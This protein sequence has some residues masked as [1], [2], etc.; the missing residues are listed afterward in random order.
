MQDYFNKFR[1]AGLHFA[2]AKERVFDLW[3]E[4]NQV[5]M[6]TM[7]LSF[8]RLQG[9]LFSYSFPYEYMVEQCRGFGYIIYTVYSWLKNAWVEKLI[10]FAEPE[11]LVCSDQY[12]YSPYL[13]VP[14]H[15]EEIGDNLYVDFCNH[16]HKG[17][18]R[19]QGGK[20]NQCYMLNKVT[21]PKGASHT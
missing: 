11:Y 6:R 14:L 15:R 16:L 10:P 1:R 13:E 8:L 19:F 17:Y 2:V 18:M 21:L 7:L 3:T 20:G 12:I 4:E 9:G 5:E